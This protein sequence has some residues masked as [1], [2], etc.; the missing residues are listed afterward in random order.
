MTEEDKSTDLVTVNPWSGLRQYTAARIALG[1]SGLSMPTAPQ[2]AFQ[3]AHAQA[4]DAVHHELNAASLKNTLID[5]FGL[6]QA[7]C[8]LLQ[9]SAVDRSTYL[10][11]PDFGR[12][13]SDSSRKLLAGYCTESVPADQHRQFD[14]AFV[15]VDGLSALAIEHNALAFLQLAYPRFK[16]DGL[17]IAPFTIVQQGRVAIGDEIGERLGAKLVVVMIGER[18]GL[19]S[20]DSMG[21]YITWQPKVGLTD[22]SRNCISNIHTAGLSYSEAVHKLHYLATEARTRRLT[23]VQ[24]KDETGSPEQQIAVTTGN[25]LLS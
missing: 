15:L 2:L 24:L 21:L 14:L 10:K 1:R 8:I 23:G 3:L 6:H 17:N 13:L 25:F 16:Q 22:E 7:E 11:R 4:R 9:S 5:T 19:S 18:P 12:T 20:P